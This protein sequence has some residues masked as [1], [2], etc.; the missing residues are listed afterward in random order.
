VI[1]LGGDADSTGA[2]VGGIAG[3]TVGVGHIPAEWLDGLLGWPR[4]VA[5]MR[6]L[7]E[8]LARQF[9]VERRPARQGPLPLF[10]PGLVPRSLLFLAV[11]LAPPSARGY[12][13]HS[14]RAGLVTQAA[15]SGVSERSIQDQSGHK[16]LTVM[17]RYIRDGSLFREK[18]CGESRSLTS[19]ERPIPGL[20]VDL[21]GKRQISPQ[22]P[23]W[24]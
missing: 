6:A 7:A 17:R 20:C 5:W 23:A 16:S 22:Y 8:R 11:V 15:M 19:A 1:A 2:V 18:R 4:S 12:S 21:P 9:P 10:W 13:G 24:A 3:A 14:L